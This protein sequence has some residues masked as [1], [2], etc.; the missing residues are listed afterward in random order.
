MIRNKVPDLRRESGLTQEELARRLNVTRQTI[1][2]LEKNRY[3]PSLE[4]A[5]KVAALFAKEVE[6][7]FEY[8]P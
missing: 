5:F 6:E 1:I 7:I 4:M 2:S 3:T 8:I